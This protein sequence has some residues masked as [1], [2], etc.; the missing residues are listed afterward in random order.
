ML[1]LRWQL[2]FVLMG[3]T[4][5]LAFKGKTLRKKKKNRRYIQT[6][7]SQSATERP[8]KRTLATGLLKKITAPT[9][10]S[11]KILQY[12]EHWG[13]IPNASK[14]EHR[15]KRGHQ[16]QVRS[17]CSL[18]TIPATQRTGSQTTEKTSNMPEE[19]RKKT[20]LGEH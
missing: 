20:E 12:T 10:L 6:N 13:K 15:H 5:D 11:S 2:A 18:Q 17:A 16:H 1:L 4:G 8:N 14:S 7:R 3:E 9:C 19:V